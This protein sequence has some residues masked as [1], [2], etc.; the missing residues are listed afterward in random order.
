MAGEKEE[1]KDEEKNIIV[2]TS[3]DNNK[4]YHTHLIIYI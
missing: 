4:P 3:L 1:E 2:T